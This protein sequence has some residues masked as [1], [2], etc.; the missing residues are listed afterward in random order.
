MTPREC[1]IHG[2]VMD[3]FMLSQDMGQA[4]LLNEA[5]SRLAGISVDKLCTAE[6]APNA[7]LD[8]LRALTGCPPGYGVVQ[9][10]EHA[11]D[12]L[13]PK[14]L[15]G[16]CECGYCFTHCR[17]DDYCTGWYMGRNNE[18]PTVA[19]PQCG[20]LLDHRKLTAT[21][22]PAYKPEEATA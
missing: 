7:A 13:E 6:T 8:R 2:L 15:Q 17:A 16:R 5:L 21:P 4:E 10:L 12:R 22:H 14:T 18:T 19:C 1:R 3:A 20:S 9:A 11:G